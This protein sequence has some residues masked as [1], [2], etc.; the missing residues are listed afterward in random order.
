MVTIVSC[1]QGIYIF[2]YFLFFF[3]EIVFD[4][5]TPTSGVPEN[6]KNYKCG[7]ANTDVFTQFLRIFFFKS[8][9]LHVANI[10][11]HILHYFLFLIV[12]N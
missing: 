7:Y 8:L 2:F 1:T 5:I 6:L 11:T 4:F 10:N 3:I 12:P 9:F